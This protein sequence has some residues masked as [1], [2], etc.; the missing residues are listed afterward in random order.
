MYYVYFQPFS[1]YALDSTMGSLDKNGSAVENIEK[2]DMAEKTD[3]EKAG[4]KNNR[5]YGVE[6]VI[7][8]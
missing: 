3:A 2:I 7:T 1:N 4:D 6:K 8:F 5:S